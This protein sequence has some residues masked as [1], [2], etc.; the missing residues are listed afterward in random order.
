MLIAA[1][2]TTA[3]TWKQP[4]CLTDEWIKMWYIYTKEWILL[5]HKKEQNNTIC[6]NMDGTRDSH[7]KW[8]KSERERQIPYDITCIYNLI[9]GTNE[10]FHRKETHRLEEQTCGCQVGE[11]RSGMDRESGVNRCK[12]LHLEWKSSEILLYSTG[13]ST[14]YSVVTYMGKESEQEWIYV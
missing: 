2:F 13:N 9:Y 10:P 1:L 7:T 14:Q 11:E 3:K 5:S 6:S 4:I 8:S 12:L